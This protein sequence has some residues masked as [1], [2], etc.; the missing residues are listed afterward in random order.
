MSDIL[1]DNITIWSS[2]GGMKIQARGG[3]DLPGEISNVTW[4]NIQLE[5][6]VNARRNSGRSA[7]TFSSFECG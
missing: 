1:F 4:S 5:T 7:T 3:G 6:Q 2:N